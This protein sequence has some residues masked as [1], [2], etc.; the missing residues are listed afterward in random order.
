MSCVPHAHRF[1]FTSFRQGFTLIELLIVVGIIGTLASV[2]IVAINPN[3]Q[4]NA[5]RD[6]TRLSNVKQLQSALSQYIVDNGSFPNAALI[7]VSPANAKPVCK[8]GVTGDATCVNLDALVP[9]YIVALPQEALE[10]TPNHSGYLVDNNAGRPEVTASFL[11][12]VLNPKG[13]T[14]LSLWLKADALALVDGTQVS[15]WADSSGFGRNATQATPS[16][17]PIYRVN[18]FNGK[19]VLRFNGT[20]NYMVLGDLSAAFPTAASLFVVAKL[21]ATNFTLYSNYNGNGSWW[22][23]GDGHGYLGVFRT[24]RVDQYPA[25]MPATGNWLFDVISSS[26]TYQMYKNSIGQGVQAPSFYA[27]A[28]HQIGYD[29][30]IGQYFNG[31]I[32]EI[33]IYNTALTDPER[34]AVEAYLNSKYAIY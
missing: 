31:D 6:A 1:G 14:G 2:T 7:P 16:S 10:P 4:L 33:L 17:Q 12:G 29:Q 22:S 20:S 32:P 27:G 9:T 30:S 23:Y 24:G 26:S 21:N 3:K 13:I 28:V 25:S 19:P 11:G 5:A 15:S 18:A 8:Q 34:Q